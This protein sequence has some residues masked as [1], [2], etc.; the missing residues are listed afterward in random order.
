MKFLGF[1]LVGCFIA[2]VSCN[3]R[4]CF[5]RAAGEVPPRLGQ[6]TS[7]TS[8]GKALSE[9]IKTNNLKLVLEIGT[10][11]G[12]GSTHVIS[13]AIRN[14]S[15]CLFTETQKC[16][17]SF[18]VT[19]EAFEEAWE[20]SSRYLQNDPVW[21]VLG[22]TVGVEDMLVE[23]EIPYRDDHFYLYYERD[24]NIMSRQIPQLKQ[25]CEIFEFDFAL[26]DG[27]EYTGWGEFVILRD[28]CKPR[29][30]ALHDTGTLKTIK[31]EHYLKLNP[32]EAKLISSGR[33]GASWSIYE[34][35]NNFDDVSVESAAGVDMQGTIESKRIKQE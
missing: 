8:F 21:L 22:T 29:F 10:W 14:Y 26:I 32:N 27:N 9:L 34:F 3:E 13:D 7:E 18:V 19:F 12:G 11:Y 17:H 4:I 31:I 25:F 6:I 20:Y 35:Q 15:D 16:C 30:I 23:D 2:C 28:V 24:K 33:D 5:P 1:S